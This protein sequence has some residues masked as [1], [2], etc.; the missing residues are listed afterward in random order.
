VGIGAMSTGD[1]FGISGKY[2]ASEV[3]TLWRF[4]NQFIN[5]NKK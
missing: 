2:S 3:T 1:G 4:K 5:E